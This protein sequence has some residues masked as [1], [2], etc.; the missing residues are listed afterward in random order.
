ML[1]SEDLTT[2]A[3][4]IDPHKSLA[5]IVIF[6]P[7]VHNFLLKIT[8]QFLTSSCPTIQRNSMRHTL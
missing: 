6:F 2:Q 7:C 5:N 3:D 1:H 8:A 4:D